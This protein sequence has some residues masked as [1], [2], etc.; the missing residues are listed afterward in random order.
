MRVDSLIVDSAGAVRYAPGIP[1]ITTPTPPPV[2]LDAV[3]LAN[4]FRPYRAAWVNPEHVYPILA[5]PEEAP[6]SSTRGRIPKTLAK[7]KNG[8]PVTI[9]CWGDSVT[10]GG[11]ASQ[12]SSRYVDVFAAE[13][14]KRFPRGPIDVRNISVGGS[15][16]LNWLD[17]AAHPFSLITRQP[18]LNFDRIAA[19]RPDLVTLEF[20]NDTGLGETTWTAAYA[21][22]L[23]RLNEIGAELI[24]ITPHFTHPDWM[25][26]ASMRDAENRPYVRFLTEF[27]GA[28]GVALADA[29]GRWQ[30]LWCEGLPFLTLLHNSVNHPDDRGHRLFAEEL[31]KCFQ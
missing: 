27:A 11:N 8:E 18:D 14:A 25:G 3:R 2:Y 30:H 5:R 17:P 1:H 21:G 31:W 13:L 12:P 20:V 23:S 6:T 28:R 16:S 9:V 26:F 29:S 7:L 19:A 24:L 22:I 10:E 4:I 15:C